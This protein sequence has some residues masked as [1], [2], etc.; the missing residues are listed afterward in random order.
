MSLFNPK[1]LICSMMNTEPDYEAALGL[2]KH[3]SSDELKELIN[4]ESK[5]NDVLK[6]LPQMKNLDSEKE[7]LLAANKSLAEFNLSFEPKLLNGREELISK[8]EKCTSTQEQINILTQKLSNSSTKRSPETL[9]QLLKTAAQESEEETENL[10]QSFLNNDP[11]VENFVEEFV[12]KRSVAHLR[13]I[14]VEKIC[15]LLTR[16]KMENQQNALF[17][18]PIVTNP[19]STPYPPNLPNM[20]MPPYPL[21]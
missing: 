7:M 10:I 12:R 14:K 18:P 13:K 8:Y 6:D 5:L 20:A 1:F 11:S 19:W 2:V 21:M 15:E 17:Q 4:D 9:Q 3:L 16:S